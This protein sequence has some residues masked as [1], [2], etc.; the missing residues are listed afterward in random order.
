MGPS[1]ET[2]LNNRYRIEAMLGQGGMGAVYLAVD[3]ALD[4][5]VAVKTNH[6]P[7][8]DS[9]AQFLREARLLAS[10]RHPNLPRVTDY[11]I[12]DN[13]Q[14]LVMD[15]ISGQDLDTLIKETG[16][17]PVEKVA[18][19]AVQLGEAI[20]FLHH[21]N[22][23]IIHRD[24]KPANVRLNEEG[25]VVL[26]DFGIAKTVDSSQSTTASYSHYT[27]GYAPPEQYGG[28][29]R[30]G[31]YTDQYSLAALVY[32]LITGEKPADAIR[33]ALGREQLAPM[34]QFADSIPLNLQAAVERALSLR[35]V[36]RF[37]DIDDFIRAILPSF[38]PTGTGEITLI[39]S[40][41]RSSS[42]GQ[43]DQSQTMPFSDT[44]LTGKAQ[45]PVPPPSQPETTQPAQPR[46]KIS[47]F[48]TI[49]LVL[50]CLGM[51]AAT[52]AAVIFLPRLLYPT[53]VAPAA[54][55]ASQTPRPAAETWAP[56]PSLALPPSQTPLLPTTPSPS[57]TP[58]ISDTPA[59]S[60]TPA[61][62]VTPLSI[63][64]GGVIVFSSN[65]LDG[66]ADGKMIFQLWTMR[67]WI[68][69]Q[70]QEIAGD[71]KQ[72]TSSEGDKRQPAW[73]PDGKQ[74]AYVSPGKM[75]NEIWVM[76]ADGSGDPVAITSL[77]GDESEPAWSPDGKWIAFTSDGR[78]DRVLMLY[79]VHPDGS[80]LVKLSTFQ[81]ES[82]PTWSPQMDL[83][84]VMNIAGSQVLY[85]RG[86]NDTQ[87][88][89]TPTQPYYVT[90]VFF[91][92][93]ALHGNLGQVSEPSWSPE[94]HW[95]AY[96]RQRVSG[97]SIYL[98]HYPVRAPAEKDILRLTDSNADTS[99]AWSPDGQWIVFTSKREGNSEIYIMR[100]T[101]KS[102]NNL[103][104][105]PS[106][107]LDPAWR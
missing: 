88:G 106:E 69:D 85:V 67:V 95:V 38:A 84:F 83:G 107:D 15:Y 86:Q 12:L 17:Q 40:A 76:N 66:S 99:P 58:I 16:R 56:S 10:L 21:Q 43:V 29:I 45:P 13:I 62:S 9:T 26:V 36:D 93:L 55:Q 47:L 75:G 3:T 74:I 14:Y 4:T 87:T 80:G 20:S 22:P 19:W 71:L 5:Q 63:G 39:S 24:V 30:P 101:G 91:D 105:N 79:L 6:S 59:H 33:R 42:A 53:R 77:K 60:D 72:I 46:R 104:L 82:G 25:D 94:G 28:T 34:S 37:P 73:S 2:L 57:V 100:S 52:S 54:I 64:G 18:A 23:P 27:P 98:A 50:A 68:N 81:Q 8:P 1:P 90:P 97:S 65:R 102:Q 103:T 35:P 11:F 92:R 31:V 48:L 32:H 96:V 61:P 78:E 70:G 51:A 7:A 49:V 44:Q 89:A 41:A